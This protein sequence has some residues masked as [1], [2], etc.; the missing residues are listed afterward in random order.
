[1]VTELDISTW[2]RKSQYYFFK[3]YQ[4]PFFNIVAN[5]DVDNLYQYCK[6]NKLSFFLGCLFISLKTANDIFEF[7]LRFKEDKV[8]IY[9][10]IHAGSTILT[11]NE[12]FLFCHFNFNEDIKAFCREGVLNIQRQKESNILDVNA[13]KQALIYHTSIPWISFT[14]VSNTQEFGKSEGIPKIVFGKFFEENG[15]KKMPLSVE[16]HHALMDGFHIGK[17]FQNFQ[18]NADQIAD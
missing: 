12:N 3:N 7:R 13:N 1:M 9:D 16:V 6:K 4:N 14:G 2:K 5:V 17:Y 8:V 10:K 18:K 15:R 11:D